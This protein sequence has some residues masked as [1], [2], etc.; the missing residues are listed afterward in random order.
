MQPGV[1]RQSAA[2]FHVI[3]LANLREAERVC[4][5]LFLSILAANVQHV[6][7]IF[8]LV[9]L[10][11]TCSKNKVCCSYDSYIEQYTFSKVLASS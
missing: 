9:K 8:N 6:D 10:N 4:H 11:Y 5:Q 7:Q 2:N 3:V 1:C